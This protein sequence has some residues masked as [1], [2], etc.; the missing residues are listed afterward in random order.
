MHFVCNLSQTSG[1]RASA[2]VR[3]PPASRT[4]SAGYASPPAAAAALREASCTIPCTRHDVAWPP[5]WPAPATA[6][7][8]AVLAELCTQGRVGLQSGQQA[9]TRIAVILA[10][11]GGPAA[12]VQVGDCVELLQVAAGM[13]ATSEVHAHSPLFYQLLRSLGVP[14]RGRARRD[15]RCSP[16]AGSRPASS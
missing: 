6:A 3:P 11:K 9:L 1:C 8:F 10:A 16:A 12:A 7:A 4:T 5:R 13:R 14:G 15:A 2:E